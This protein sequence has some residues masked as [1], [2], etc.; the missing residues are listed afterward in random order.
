MANS[1]RIPS[2]IQVPIYRYDEARAHDAWEC[3]QAL[4]RH[5]RDNPHLRDN[6][7]WMM[8]RADAYEQFA[9]SF[10]ALL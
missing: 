1:K 3:H 6:A 9:L 8:L 7:Q 5:E 10:E 2:A 4:L